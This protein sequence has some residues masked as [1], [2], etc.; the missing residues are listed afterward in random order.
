MRRSPARRSRVELVE[1]EDMRC[2]RVVA[3]A[4][5]ADEGERRRP[6]TGRRRRQGCRAIVLVVPIPFILELFS[7]TSLNPI[8]ETGI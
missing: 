6:R 4:E 3:V 2:S 5:R 8:S 1:V 7:K